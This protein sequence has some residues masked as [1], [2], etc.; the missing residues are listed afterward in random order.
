MLLEGQEGQ[1]EAGLAT[2]AEALA[3]AQATGGHWFRLLQINQRAALKQLF[4]ASIWAGGSSAPPPLRKPL[5]A[6]DGSSRARGRHEAPSRTPRSVRGGGLSSWHTYGSVCDRPPSVVAE[7]S[8]RRPGEAQAARA[9]REAGPCRAA[10]ETA[11]ARAAV[12]ALAAAC[13]LLWAGAVLCRLGAASS[14]AVLVCR[15]AGLDD[16]AHTTG[17][18]PASPPRS[19]TSEHLLAR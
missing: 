10:L 5:R 9:W 8:G 15:C 16:P 6:L 4:V 11:R 3:A 1:V 14:G 2:L 13:V 12:G 19:A 17:S 7:T 18:P